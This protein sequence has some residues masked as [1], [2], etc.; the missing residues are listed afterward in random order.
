M[1]LKLSL[2]SFLLASSAL[3]QAQ[4]QAPPPPPPGEAA[5]QH[6]PTPAPAESKEKAEQ[7]KWRV[8]AP[9]GLSLRKVP[10][11]TD[12][13]T[14]MNV[15]V[16]PDGTRVAFDMLGDIYVMPIGGGTPTRGAASASSGQRRRLTMES[17]R[18]SFIAFSSS[19][20]GRA[21]MVP[22]AIIRSNSPWST[23]K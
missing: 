13:G 5:S 15:D 11:R 17:V 23:K 4:E 16:S 6:S 8:E 21:R 2:A 1:I 12:E 9:A 20:A 19:C 10:I 14:W 3:V 18:R 22:S 7:S